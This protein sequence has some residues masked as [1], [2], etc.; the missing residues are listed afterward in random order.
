MPLNTIDITR[1]Q[2]INTSD[3]SLQTQYRTAWNNQQYSTAFSIISNNPQL[4]SKVVNNAFITLLVN[5]I[6][7]LE[8]FYGDNVTDFLNNLLTNWQSDVDSIQYLGDYQSSTSYTVGNFVSYNDAIYMCIQ[9]GVHAITDTASWTLLGLQGEDGA[10]GT[11]LSYAGTWSNTSTYSQYD[12]VSYGSGL[13]I[14]IT[15]STGSTPSTNPNVWLLG[16]D[17]TP[18]GILTG[19]TEP[20]DI[21]TGDIWWE[22]LD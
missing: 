3:I 20:S 10:V 6:L 8:N 11:G 17:A 9:D 1:A 14:A 2:D 15:G 4:A 22:Y 7:T 16:V 5:G 13:Y 19:P 12:M 18:R 21:D